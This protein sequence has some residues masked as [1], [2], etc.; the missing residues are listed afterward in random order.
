MGGAN[1]HPWISYGIAAVV[2]VVVMAIR[3]RRSGVARPLKLGRLL[4]IPVAYGA[5]AAV[6]FVSAPPTGSGW[7]LCAAALAVGAAAGWQRGRMIHIEVDS[8]TGTLSATQS[9][10]AILF[11]LVLILVR[12]GLRVALEGGEGGVLSAATLTDMLIAFALGLLAVQRL[13]MYLR[14]KRLLAAARSA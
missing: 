7:L 10:F 14:A 11:I 4:I 9:P 12:S 2:I 5:L 8:R 13:E 3:F 6:L 1:P